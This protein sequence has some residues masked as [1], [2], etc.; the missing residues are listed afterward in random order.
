M[1]HTLWPHDMLLASIQKN[2]NKEEKV[3]AMMSFRSPVL[4]FL[5]LGQAVTDLLCVLYR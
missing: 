3:V 5:C 1:N 2:I 4:E